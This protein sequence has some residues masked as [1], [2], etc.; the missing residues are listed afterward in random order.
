MVP[1]RRSADSWS[2]SLI[3]R[4]YTPLRPVVTELHST[5][6]TFAS[7]RANRL[8]RS[9]SSPATKLFL[10]NQQSIPTDRTKPATSRAVV[11]ASDG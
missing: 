4:W 10:S 5:R 2:A 9:Q 8:L 3:S 11:S 6:T 1:R 7:W